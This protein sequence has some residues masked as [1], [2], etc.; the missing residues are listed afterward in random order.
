MPI[1]SDSL[2]ARNDATTMVS[3]SRSR[4]RQLEEKERWHDAL[5]A[6]GVDN[7][8]GI[9]EALSIFRNDAPLP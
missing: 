4:L 7:W 5:E 9:D 1:E 3:I 6:A 2:S 8:Q